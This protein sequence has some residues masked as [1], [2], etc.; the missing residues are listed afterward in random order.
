MFKLFERTF[1][2][3]KRKVGDIITRFIRVDDQSLI[4]NMP[5]YK[6]IT[7][8]IEKVRKSQKKNAIIDMIFTFRIIKNIF[9]KF[10]YFMK[11]RWIRKI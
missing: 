3:Y 1:I 9:G 4:V 6:S 5:K 2:A 8:C 10:F 11:K 7:D